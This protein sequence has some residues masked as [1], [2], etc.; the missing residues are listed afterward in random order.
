MNIDGII[1]KIYAA[2]DSHR[3]DEGVYCRWLWQNAE[4]LRKLGVNE[5]GCAD[6]ANILYTIGRFERDPEKREK[7]VMTMRSMQN[8]ETGMF[9]E[10]THHTIHTTAHVIAALE[11]FDALPAYPVKALYQYRDRDALYAKLES[12]DWDNDPWSQS[13]QGAGLFAALT[14]TRA[15]DAQWQEWYF[16]WL[17]E[18]CDPDFGMSYRGRF[19]KKPLNHHLN[20]WF[21]YLF[22]H[23]FAHRAFPYP[24]RLIDSCLDMYAGNA[25]GD[26]FGRTCNFAEIDWV[27]ALNR[28]A[29]Q[30]PH[31]FDEVKTQLR[32]FAGKYIAYMDSIDG[33]RDE[34]F[35]DLHMLFGAV[36]VLAELQQA[37]PGEITSTV[38]LKLVLDRRPFI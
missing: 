19:G 6:A 5:Y 35:N 31:R 8:P 34:S 15:V 38:P 13:H 11:L 1:E 37:L 26:N 20:G 30:T 36:C 28:A 7:W 29:R 16:G 27:F 18:K 3:L 33:A 25:L 9:T 24:E 14:I 10:A 2:V 12:L 21:H 23:N 17:R 22:N 4:G 32:D